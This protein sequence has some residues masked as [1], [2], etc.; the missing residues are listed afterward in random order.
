MGG[1]RDYSLKNKK[2]TKFQC[3]WKVILPVVPEIVPEY[4]RGLVNIE[5]DSVA[6]TEHRGIKNNGGKGLS[7]FESESTQR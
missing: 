4:T 7:E 1:G 6:I 2:V 5:T 3:S